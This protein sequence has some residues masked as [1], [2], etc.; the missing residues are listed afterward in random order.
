MYSIIESLSPFSNSDTEDLQEISN[1]IVV[2]R[3]KARKMK[4]NAEV[5]HLFSSANEFKG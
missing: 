4:Q 5:Y 2:A 1:Q 3:V